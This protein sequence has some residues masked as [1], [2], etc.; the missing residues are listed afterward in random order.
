VR[1]TLGKRQLA[2]RFE[3][4]ASSISPSPGIRGKAFRAFLTRGP[5][6]RAEAPPGKETRPHP[7][8]FYGNGGTKFREKFAATFCK[9][10]RLKGC[11]A[12]IFQRDFRCFE[13]NVVHVRLNMNGIL[14]LKRWRSRIGLPRRTRRKRLQQL[15]L[16]L[17]PKDRRNR[18]KRF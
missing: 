5:G 2:K 13:K 9:G 4:S 18:S 6:S 11:T 17:W 3:I 1:T 7:S 10:K 14:L 16:N 15:E 12:R 8:L